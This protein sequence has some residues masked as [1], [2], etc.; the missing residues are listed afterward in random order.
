[1]NLARSRRYQE[2]VSEI[3]DALCELQHL[4]LGSRLAYVNVYDPDRLRRHE[5]VI[6]GRTSAGYYGPRG[7]AATEE[8][9]AGSVGSRTVAE[10]GIDSGS[11]R[12]YIHL[13]W[14]LP[15]QVL[16]PILHRPLPGK[17]TGSD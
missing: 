16:R 7:E 4:H 11:K 3:L 6:V 15:Q 14:R 13:R 9:L 5:L 1:M 12:T 2:A 17:K 10:P 8:E